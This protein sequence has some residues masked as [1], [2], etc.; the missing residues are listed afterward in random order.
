MGRVAASVRVPGRVPDAEALWYDPARW[1]VWVEGFGHVLEVGDGW[2]AAGAR[3]VWAGPPGGRER[4]VER[5]LRREPG[6]GEVQVEDPRVRGRRTASF[7]P[8]GD[9]V[10]L[11][12][13]FDY[14]L[15]LAPALSWAMDLLVERRRQSAALRRSLARFARERAGDLELEAEASR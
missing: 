10:T 7:T 2:P 8:A 1:P 12:V 9:G 5:V 11:D 3:V 14:E 6:S 15:K 13:S 4:V